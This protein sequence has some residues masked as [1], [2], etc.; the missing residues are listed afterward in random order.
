MADDSDDKRDAI[1]DA[2]QANAPHG[3]DAILTGWALVTEWMDHDG[4]RWLSKAH[5][6]ATTSW[7]ADGMHHHALHGD[8]PD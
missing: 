8:W 4:E 5:A 3:L 7:A 6:A 1:H 2:I